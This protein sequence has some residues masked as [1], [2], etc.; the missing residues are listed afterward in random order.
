MIDEDDPKPGTDNPSD[1]E[2]PEQLIEQYQNL[3]KDICQEIKNIRQS[4]E[5]LAAQLTRV[6]PLLVQMQSLLSQRG[7]LHRQCKKLGLP[8][9][10]EWQYNF[11]RQSG[12]EASLSTVKRAMQ[13]FHF[14]SS[15]A[16]RTAQSVPAKTLDARRAC[17]AALVALEVAEAFEAGR[18]LDGLIAK[19][20]EMNITKGSMITLLQ[21]L[22]VKE[23]PQSSGAPADSEP[24]QYQ[25]PAPSSAGPCRPGAWSQW[26][27]KVDSM[28]G[29]DLRTTLTTDPD[30]QIKTL[31]SIYKHLAQKW[32]PYNPDLMEMEIEVRYVVKPN[33]KLRAA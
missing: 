10:E 21:K 25:Q 19:L 13:R 18:N 8:S 33:P 31:E 15:A 9:W 6:C 5:T 28:L 22:G 23:V 16:L 17:Y 4:S 26:A 32:T 24:V 12:I 27:E 29:P 14:G 30:L 7:K 20:R 3:N 2:S 11:V 1:A